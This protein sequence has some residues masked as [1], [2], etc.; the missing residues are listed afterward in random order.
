MIP[1]FFY[2][3][4]YKNPLNF[5]PYN[6][7][8]GF[9]YGDKFFNKEHQSKT[10]KEPEKKDF[11]DSHSSVHKSKNVNQ[12]FDDILLIAIIFFLYNEGVKDESLFIVLVMLLFNF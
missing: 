9:S 2:R 3:N 1:S 8:N 12:N 7:Y 4:P 6:R 10:K 5:Y 11:E